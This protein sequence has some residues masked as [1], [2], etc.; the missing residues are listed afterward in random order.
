MKG[1][2]LS[3][4]VQS[5]FGSNEYVIAEENTSKTKSLRGV[6]P[7]TFRTAVGCSTTAI[8]GHFMAS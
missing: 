4:I 1:K 8:L 5:A 3:C 2:K 6:E 7:K